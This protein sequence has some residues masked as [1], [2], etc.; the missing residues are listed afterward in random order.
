MTGLISRRTLFGNPVRTGFKISPDGQRLSWLA[1]V[2]DVL[3]IWIGP[4]G[5]L[6]LGRPVTRDRGRGVTNY[7]WAYDGRHLIYVQD[8]DGNEDHHVFAVDLTDDSVR[9]LTPIPGVAAVIGDV[10]RTLRDSIVVGLNDRDPR[11][12]DLWEIQLATGERR[13]VQENPDF[14]GFILDE[15]YR[16]KV[17]ARTHPDGSVAYL[18][19]DPEGGGWEPW[20]SFAAED[21]RVSGGLHL[22]ESGASLFCR[23]SRGRDTA[24]LVRIDLASDAVTVLAAHDEADIGGIIVDR[25]TFAPLAYAVNR[26]RQR[27]VVLDDRVRDDIAF[28]DAQELGDWYLTSRSEDDRLWVIIGGSDVRPYRVYLYDRAARSFREIASM[29]PALDGAPL[30]PMRAVVIRSRDGLDLVS[31][32]TRPLGASDAPGPLVLVVHGGPW[33]RDA[34]GFDPTHQ[35]LANRGYAALSVNFRSSTGFGKAFLNAGDG[36][37]GRRMDDDLLDAVAWAIAEGVAAPD[38]IAIFG[39]SYGGYATLAAL[40][41]NPHTYAC[42][43]DIVGPAN[44][45]TLIR[46]IPPY[47]ESALAQLKRAIGDPDTEAGMALIR[48]RSPVYAADRI[49][50]PLMIAQGANDPRVKKDEADQMVAA[51]DANGVPVTYLLFPDEGH[52]FVRPPNRLTFF[53]NAEQFLSRCLGGRVE[54]ITRAESDGANM[55]VLRGEAAVPPEGRPGEL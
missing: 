52:G 5:D 38:K 35:W 18:R 32:L 37:W 41:R 3:N 24:A 36:E 4:V 31:Y 19:P 50:V 53:A 17:A 13:L 51:M 55:E 29:Q 44:L 11:F 23:D 54:P 46:T 28:L 2:D 6:A 33:S 10:S 15:R 48:E 20:F 45:E 12:H 8:Q 14:A 16:V 43:V 27:W 42:G 39:G 40:T 26:E 7:A 21:A 1:P 34:F 49:R 25:T 9:D 47:W 30:A 22:D